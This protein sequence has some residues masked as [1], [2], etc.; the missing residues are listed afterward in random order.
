[1]VYV[2]CIYI[3]WNTLYVHVCVYIHQLHHIT[4]Y[5]ITWY[6][7]TLCTY[8]QMPRVIL[9]NFDI[10][11][12]SVSPKWHHFFG[13]CQ[14]ADRIRPHQTAGVLQ[15]LFGAS[16]IS[17]RGWDPMAM[18]PYGTHGRCIPFRSITGRLWLV[19][20]NKGYLNRSEILFVQYH[21]MSYH[22]AWVKIGFPTFDG[23]PLNMAMFSGNNL[24]CRCWFWSMTAK[25]F[26]LL[27]AETFVFV[28]GS[29]ANCGEVKGAICECFVLYAEAWLQMRSFKFRRCQLQSWR[30]VRWISTQEKYQEESDTKM[31]ICAWANRHFVQQCQV[32]RMQ[33]WMGWPLKLYYFIYF[34]VYLIKQ[35]CGFPSF[36]G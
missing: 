36:S 31:H 1:M 16:E 28:C 25:S 20:V 34:M 4:S 21:V 6:D 7:I 24:R 23:F 2:Q 32:G 27:L 17:A 22:L 14:T 8:T 11:P 13:P 26:A 3:I 19:K 18:A 15:W 12:H 29:L 35:F 33:K 9:C 5:H 30:A 10:C